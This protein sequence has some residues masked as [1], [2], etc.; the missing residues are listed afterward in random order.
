MKP[1]NIIANLLFALMCGSIL[2]PS[3]EGTA[4]AL[5]L[6][7]SLVA[8]HIGFLAAML[9]DKSAAAADIAVIVYL[10]L[11]AWE[12]TTAKLGLFNPIMFPPPENVFDVFRTHTRL[13]AVGFVD[14]ML[15]LAI[16]FSSAVAAAV[17]FGMLIGW[18]PKLKNSLFP[19]IKALAPIPPLVYTSYV[20]GIMPSFRAAAVFVIFLGVFFPNLIGIISAVSRMDKDIID[21]AK[22]LNVSRFTML[23]RILLPYITPAVVNTNTSA[24][25]EKIRA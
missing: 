14:S 18:F 2:S 8:A 15:R 12:V 20:I 24:A 21:N 25:P 10:F 5:V 6:L 3:R 11:L 13:L 19:I 16:G 1:R 4:G 22:S 7:A 17:L 9:R 23:Y